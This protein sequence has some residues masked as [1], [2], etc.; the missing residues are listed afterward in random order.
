[1]KQ[2]WAL[3]VN[4]VYK[5]WFI[6]KSTYLEMNSKNVVR[7][8]GKYQSNSTGGGLGGDPGT[9]KTTLAKLLLWNLKLINQ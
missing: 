3:K 8:I 1:M 6:L 4:G 9:G 2:L 5:K 7:I